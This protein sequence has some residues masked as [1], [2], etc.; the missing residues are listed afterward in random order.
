M[1]LL[2]FIDCNFFSGPTE[3]FHSAKI[4]NIEQSFHVHIKGAH[5]K[6]SIN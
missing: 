4:S 3:I 1:G 5:D 6:Q 2:L